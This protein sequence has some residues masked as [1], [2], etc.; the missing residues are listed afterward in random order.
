MTDVTDQQEFLTLVKAELD[1][2]VDLLMDGLPAGTHPLFRPMLSSAM[3]SAA[4]GMMN[5]ISG[6]YHEGKGYWLIPKDAIESYGMD[7]VD[8]GPH[9]ATEYF[10]LINS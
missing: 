3:D 10:K 1:R 8:I 6:A 4:M 9:L 2:H 5:V 7:F